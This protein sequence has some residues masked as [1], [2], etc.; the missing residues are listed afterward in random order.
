MALGAAV[1]SCSALGF[2]LGR[3][4][5]PALFTTDQGVVSL[6]ARILPIVAAFQL[7]DSTQVICA[8]IL[9]GL[10]RPNAGALINLVGYF[11][12]ALPLA[13]F[14][15]FHRELGLH[16]IWYALAVGLFSVAALLSFWVKRTLS[17]PVASLQVDG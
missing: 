5:L 6:A 13:Y 2:V 11:A 16:G 10:G 17:S 4:A 7:F 3:D 12:F 1:M 8:G 14:L 15:A 9:R